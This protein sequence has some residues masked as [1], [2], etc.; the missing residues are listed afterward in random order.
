M[1]PFVTLSN[2]RSPCPFFS[3][4]LCPLSHSLSLVFSLRDKVATGSFD[5]T[6]KLWSAETGKCF[7]TFRGHTA[8][9]VRL[10]SHF[11][12]LKTLFSPCIHTSLS[13]LKNSSAKNDDSVIIY[14]HLCQSKPFFSSM[15]H[16]RSFCPY[17][18]NQWR[19]TE[20]QTDKIFQSFR[21]GMT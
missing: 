8:E 19:P 15:E 17:N 1:G 13:S 9:I 12:L 18:E 11:P 2:N 20:F 14:S 21:F 3:L 16:K 10:H 7:Y 6:C 4:P 5:K